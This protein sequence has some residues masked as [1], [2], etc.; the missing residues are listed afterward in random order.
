[1]KTPTTTLLLVCVWAAHAHTSALRTPSVHRSPASVRL[2][3][4]RSPAG[5]HFLHVEA[6]NQL[7]TLRLQPTSSP[8][9]DGFRLQ[10]TSRNEAGHL[11]LEDIAHE[12]D[13]VSE[14]YE[15]P[16]AGGVVRLSS[17]GVEGLLSPSLALRV[18]SDGQHEVVRQHYETQPMQGTDYLEVPHEARSHHLQASATIRSLTSATVEMYI[19]VD[20]TLAAKLGSS[21]K[22]KQY[23]GVFWNAVNMR[24]A[25]ITDPQIRLVLAAA[26]IVSDADDEIYITDNILTQNY[27]HGQNTL[28]SLSNWL[29]QR[30]DS[31][32]P[33]DVV[34][35]MTGKDM[36]NVEGGMIQKALAGIA[37]RAAACFV[38]KDIKRSFNTAMGE[39]SS[40]YT[41]VM[42]AAHEVAHNLGAPHDGD[43]GSE[44]CPWA[45]GYIMSY[46]QGNPNKMFFSSCSKDQMKKYI[47]RSDAA[48][49]HTNTASKPIPLSVTLPGEKLDMDQQCQAAT[50][51]T[52]AYA[53]KSASEDSLCLQLVCQWK[54][55]EGRYLYTYTQST[56]IP[57]AEGSPCRSGG[58]CKGGTCQ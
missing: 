48:C 47:S 36:V 49:L 51:Q 15:D 16:E 34:Y 6:F 42:T 28:N 17:A 11:I 18:G 8:F 9:A 4:A 39:D 23:L 38:G 13:D 2:E 10:T 41:G 35:L 40:Y 30:K 24:Y 25:T 43:E 57:A 14:L 44:S 19:I 29:F 56:G 27:I 58:A 53:S 46:V 12:E 21:E 20:S 33:H 45:D 7:H 3:A 1:M 55:Q 26:L 52:D 37:W 54:K 31:L 32:P 50:G 22:V 5:P